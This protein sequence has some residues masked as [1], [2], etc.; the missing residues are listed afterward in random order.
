MRFAARSLASLLLLLP[1]AARAAESGSFLVQ[2]GQDTTSVERYTRSASRIEVTQV[3]RAPRTLQR[4]FVYDLANNAFTHVSFTAVPPGSSTPTQ[5]IEATLDADSLRGSTVNGT[6]APQPLRVAVP[7]GALVVFTSSPWSIYENRIAQFVKTKADTAGGPLYFMGGPTL[8]R[9]L[10]RRLGRDSVEIRTMDHGDNYHAA[11]DRAGRI[12][13][14]LPVAG[15]QKFTVTRQSAIDVEG[16]AASFMAREK[17]G[18]GLGIL[19]VR[20]TLR[21]AS[22]NGDSIL[23]DYGRPAK[24]GRQVFGSA[25]VPFGEVWRT[26]ANA[27]TQFRT[28]RALDF[29]GT[30]V[31]AGS[32][33]LWTLPTATGWTLIVNGETGQ[34]GTQHKPE[35]DLY[36]IPLQVSTLPAVVERFTIGVDRDGPAGTLNLDWDT[37]RAS[38]AFTVKPIDM[39]Q[40]ADKK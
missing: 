9:Y 25:V 34:W 19:S 17:A 37:T 36:R 22:A 1:F 4:H 30:V 33:T 10:L 23:I 35:R 2:L 7:K 21:V 12:M 40:A 18:Q 39:A 20:D 11:I 24:R 27:A 29:G 38:A 3:G 14:I 6:A 28:N 5:S 32:Y 26:G 31:P 8:D 16:L 15:T 13:G